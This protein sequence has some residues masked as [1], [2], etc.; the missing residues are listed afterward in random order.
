MYTSNKG[1]TDIGMIGKSKA[2]QC[3][4]SR[5]MSGNIHNDKRK[6]VKRKLE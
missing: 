3:Y 5:S 4:T 2:Y 6:R 1:Q